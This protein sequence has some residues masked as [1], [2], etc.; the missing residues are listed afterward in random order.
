LDFQFARPRAVDPAAPPEFSGP[1]LF[2]AI[3][4]Q[5]GLKLEKAEGTLNVIVVEGA[6]LPAEN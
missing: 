2:T 4:E 1:S 6:R 3:R 5:W